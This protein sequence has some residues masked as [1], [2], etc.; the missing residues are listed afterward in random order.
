M[1]Y[2]YCTL[3]RSIVSCMTYTLHELDQSSHVLHIASNFDKSLP[4]NIGTALYILSAVCPFWYSFVYSSND[5]PTAWMVILHLI[6][7]L[8][9]RLST[10]EQLKLTP[11]YS[12]SPPTSFHSSPTSFHSPPNMYHLVRTSPPTTFQ[13]PP[14]IFQS[15][16][17]KFFA[18]PPTT[19]IFH[20]YFKIGQV[21]GIYMIFGM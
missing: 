5:C 7:S 14:T 6:L 12:N 9:K 10:P 15:S 18:S 2:M 19:F 1:R 20:S 16:P 11:N 3:V 4:L 13:A 21:I 17:T 8:L